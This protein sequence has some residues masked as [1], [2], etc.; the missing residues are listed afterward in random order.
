MSDSIEPFTTGDYGNTTTHALEYIL[1]PELLPSQVQDVVVPGA[2]RFSKA[3]EKPQEAI[4][5]L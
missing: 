3:A 2:K 4:R 1:V 5:R